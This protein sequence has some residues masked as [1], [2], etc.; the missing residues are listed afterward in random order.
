MWKTILKEIR[1]DK[2]SGCCEEARTRIVDWYEGHIQNNKLVNKEGL[3]RMQSRYSELPCEELYAEFE[4]MVLNAE[5]A[6]SKYDTALEPYDDIY[7]LREILDEWDDCREE[8]ESVEVKEQN[9]A[10]DNFPLFQNDPS[11]WMNQFIRGRN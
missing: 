4:E 9:P 11:A 2:Q 5:D 7:S 8:P 6:A 3:L 1:M 10:M